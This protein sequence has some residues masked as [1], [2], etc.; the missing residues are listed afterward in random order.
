MA[1]GK[2]I[3]TIE[4]LA[5]K[6]S[7]RPV[8]EA[9]IADDAFQCRYCTRGQIMAARGLVIERRACSEQAIPVYHATGKRIRDLP[10]TPGE[11]LTA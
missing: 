9:F 8:Q 4:G 1:Q 7:L 2:D 11:L 5:R 6:G 10:I 3:A